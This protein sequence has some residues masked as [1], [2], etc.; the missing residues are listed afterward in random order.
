MANTGRISD[1]LNESVSSVDRSG[2]AQTF[3]YLKP[4]SGWNHDDQFLSALQDGDRIL[5]K[6]YFPERYDPLSNIAVAAKALS[7]YESYLTVRYEATSYDRIM[8]EAES[9]QDDAAF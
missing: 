2:T 3:D 9:A 6:Y 8:N 7:W 4:S 5:A 1:I